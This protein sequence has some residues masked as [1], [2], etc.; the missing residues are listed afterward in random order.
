[1]S[2]LE[3]PS[4][5][6]GRVRGGTINTIVG[7][8]HADHLPDAA[9][10]RLPAARRERHQQHRSGARWR[11][12][13]ATGYRARARGHGRTLRRLGP[14]SFVGSVVGALLLLVLPAAAF[15]AI[16]PVLIAHRPGPRPRRSVAPATG[17][18]AAPARRP[19]RHAGPLRRCGGVFVAGVYGGYFGAAQGVLLMGLFSALS[20]SRCSA[21]TAT[22][23]CSALDRQRRRRGH[24]RPLRARAH[25]LAGRRVH[26]RS[27]RSSAAW[28]ARGSAAGS[29]RRAARPHRRH[30]RRRHRQAGLVPLTVRS[31]I[32]EPGARGG[33]P[34]TPC[35]RDRG[36]TARPAW[37]TTWRSPTSRCGGGRSRSA[38]STSPRVREGHPAGA[39]APGTGH[40]RYL[41]ARALAHRPRRRRRATPRRRH[42]GLRRRARR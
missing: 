36:P 13:R 3:S 14:M 17:R 23:T 19:R 39:A 5:R 11:D 41:M 42:A 4:H 30:R 26:R 6:R 15:K 31:P 29:P 32:T 12:R 18:R 2:V 33:Q 21:S 28:S 9:L 1:M 27:G 40:G 8:G 10:L 22:R 35:V 25:R 34:C 7:S 37:P 20:P 24:L 16:V 38:G